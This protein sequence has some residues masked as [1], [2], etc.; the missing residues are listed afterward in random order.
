[1]RSN[2]NIFILSFMMITLFINSLYAKKKSQLWKDKIGIELLL[3]YGHN[4][5]K[6]SEYNTKNLKFIK[7]GVL[8]FESS[9]CYNHSISRNF[10]LQPF[11]G[12]SRFTINGDG[13][14]GD[15]TQIQF[16]TN[17]IQLGTYCKYKLRKFEPKIGFCG[18]RMMNRYTFYK[19]SGNRTNWKI[20]TRNFYQIAAGI[21]YQ[22]KEFSIG[23]VYWKSISYVTPSNIYAKPYCINEYMASITWYPLKRNYNELK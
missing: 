5:L 11:F 8:S 6:N 12:I 3:G 14:S 22:F 20:D 10:S 23:L 7:V 4:I 16:I 1:M 2:L 9:L 19:S 13:S 17:C 18:K 15:V 21:D